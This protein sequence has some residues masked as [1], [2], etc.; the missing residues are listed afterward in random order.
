MRHYLLIE[1]KQIFVVVQRLHQSMKRI[2][3]KPH[4][5]YDLFVDGVSPFQSAGSSKL[6]P[7]LAR[8]H[9]IQP[10]YRSKDGINIYYLTS[11]N[12]D[13]I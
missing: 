5:V 2:E 12:R 7:I 3:K 10:H 4:V 1:L 8:A 13:L 9:A 6:I 11:H